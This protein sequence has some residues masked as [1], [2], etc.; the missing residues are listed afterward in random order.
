MSTEAS[1]CERLA[2]SR[3]R[4]R[5]AMRQ[6]NSAETSGA[7]AEGLLGGLRD[8]LQAVPGAGLVMDGVQS[9][10]Q[11]QPMRL[12]LLLALKMANV[13]LQPVAQRH[14]YRLVLAAAAVGGLTVMLRPWRRIA[15][16]AL[17]AGL[18]PRVLSHAMKLLAPKAGGAPP[19]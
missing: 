17:L 9:W 11:N 16:S 18:M 4:L 14:P 7:N 5:Q 13:L 12:V 3:E 8:R 19:K 15:I 6:D 10:W 1:P 2:A